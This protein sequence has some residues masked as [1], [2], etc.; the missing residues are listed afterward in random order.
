MTYPRRLSVIPV[1]A[2]MPVRTKNK[3]K[4]KKHELSILANHI[5][6]NSSQPAPNQRPHHQ[7]EAKS[8]SNVKDDKPADKDTAAGSGL[9][10][11][12]PTY[13][14]S[15]TSRRKQSRKKKREF[16]RRAGKGAGAWMRRQYRR[17]PEFQMPD[18][19]PD[20]DAP[21]FF[22]R[23]RREQREI[24]RQNETRAVLVRVEGGAGGTGSREGG[25]H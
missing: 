15:Q 20:G 17:N 18:A 12:A 25:R 5:A 19:T 8:V 9:A 4:K 16:N 2:N 14:A 22:R 6:P 21:P 7:S 10:H 3:K 24:V 13:Y 1:Q 11:R 23:D